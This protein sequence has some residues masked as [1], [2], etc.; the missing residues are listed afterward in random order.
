M[1][2]KL[3]ISTILLLALVTAASDLYLFSESSLDEAAQADNVEYMYANAYSSDLDDL[4]DAYDKIDDKWDS[5]DCDDEDSSSCKNTREDVADETKNYGEELAKLFEKIANDQNENLEDSLIYKYDKDETEKIM[6]ELTELQNDANSIADDIKEIDVDKEDFGDFINDMGDE[7]DN[8]N[9]FVYEDYREKMYLAQ[10]DT[11]E[12]EYKAKLEMMDEL[13]DVYAEIDS[14]LTA[15]DVD[16]EEITKLLKDL[17]ENNDDLDDL[18]DD[19]YD[20]IS[21]MRDELSGNIKDYEKDNNLYEEYKDANE[22]N[23]EDNADPMPKALEELEE[24]YDDN[25]E[26]ISELNEKAKELVEEM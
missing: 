23:W 25:L 9:K 6:D 15:A 22:E 8:L 3:L 4:K 2:K 18:S 11:L 1:I 19:L 24:K 20:E 21:E 7:I 10:L 26:V 16:A 5:D 17:K 12:L 14:D 13:E